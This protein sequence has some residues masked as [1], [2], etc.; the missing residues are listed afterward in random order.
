MLFGFLAFLSF[1]SCFFNGCIVH[2]QKGKT[3]RQNFTTASTAQNMLSI[4]REMKEAE[5]KAQVTDTG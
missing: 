2:A 1:R 4:T 3:Q 5:I